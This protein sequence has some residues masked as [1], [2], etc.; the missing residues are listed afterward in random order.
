[1]HP[2]SVKQMT[3]REEKRQ[4]HAFARVDGLI[5]GAVWVASFCCYVYGLKSPTVGMIGNVLALLSPIMA[6]KRVRRFRDAVR[7][8]VLSFWRA[9]NYYILIFAY[10]AILFAFVQYVYFAFIDGG[11]LCHSYLSMFMQ[12]EYEAIIKDYGLTMTQISQM[13]EEISQVPAI[14]IALN[15]FVFNL[16]V[17]I[18]LSFP[19][20]LMAYRSK[21]ITNDI[22]SI[23]K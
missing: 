18:F 3:I 11:Y 6:Y 8:G 7:E 9:V 17:G 1:L 23:E 22:K 2:I 14:T 20:A 12:P 13:M 19:A 5:I 15:I 10:A 21:P 16:G 4:L